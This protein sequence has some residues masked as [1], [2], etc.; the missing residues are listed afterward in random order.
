M[1]LEYIVYVEQW[2]SSIE[3]LYTKVIVY[4]LSFSLLLVQYWN[5]QPSWS[6]AKL[7]DLKPCS[8]STNTDIII[9]TSSRN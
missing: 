4:Q 1:A 9:N 2:E 7:C 8:F 5:G 6:I 3:A